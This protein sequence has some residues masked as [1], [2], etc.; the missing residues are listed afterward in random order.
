MSER[1]EM[2][3]HIREIEVVIIV[4]CYQNG[5]KGIVLKRMEE[6]NR[7]AMATDSNETHLPLLL[8]FF[9]RLQGPLRSLKFAQ[10]PLAFELRA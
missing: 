2:L 8:G 5:I 10:R 7:L 9:S 3:L 6:P 4:R 1:E